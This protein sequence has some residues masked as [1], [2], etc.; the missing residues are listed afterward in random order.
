VV[1][2]VLIIN[3][4]FVK[5]LTEKQEIVLNFLK[6]FKSINGYTP[7]LGEIQ[8]SL[9]IVNKRGVVQYLEVLEKK[10]LIKRSGRVRGINIVEE[11]RTH[12]SDFINIPIL[13][14]ANAGDPLTFAF[15]D[16]IGTLTVDRN[17]INRKDKIFSL[18]IKGD[19]MNK[20]K[21]NHVKLES[22]NYAII[23]KDAEVSPGDAV[24]AI[25]DDAATI[26]EYTRSSDQI[27]LY[28]VS[29][30]HIHKPIYIHEQSKAFINGK[31][32]AAL[33]NNFEVQ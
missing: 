19:S 20:R 11:F 8:K 32:I 2:I 30:N 12:N 31:V 25:I 7:T 22:G 14:Y 24:L 17:L 16:K 10:G 15:E 33:N 21:I 27:I 6:Q 18:I 26:K 5:R 23:E 1:Y 28:P 3:I 29:D 4:P 13:G 9:K